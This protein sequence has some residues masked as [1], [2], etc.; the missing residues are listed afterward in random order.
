MLKPQQQLPYKR[1]R[2]LLL[3]IQCFKRNKCIA[4]YALSRVI[5][6]IH[7]EICFGNPDWFMEWLGTVDRR[8]PAY[9]S[10]LRIPPFPILWQPPLPHPMG[11]DRVWKW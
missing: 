9:H 1:H 5:H 8:Y 6:R 2:S 7:S 3:S 10:D 11:R 4:G